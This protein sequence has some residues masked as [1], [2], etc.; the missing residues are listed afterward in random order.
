MSNAA[1][2]LQQIAQ[3]L[4]ITVV[5]VSQVNQA[6]ADWQNKE[7]IEYKG[8]GEIAAVADVALWMRKSE[9]DKSMREVI[10]RKV[11]HGVPGYFIIRLS[12]PSGRVIDVDGEVGGVNSGGS[13]G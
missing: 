5:I 13:N 1:I 6:S 10:L 7:A 11:R 12:F 8:A 3:E 4:G 9:D 2:G